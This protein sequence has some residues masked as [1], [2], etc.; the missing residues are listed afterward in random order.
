MAWVTFKCSGT[1][2]EATLA[3]NAVDNGW[4]RC[5]DGYNWIKPAASDNVCVGRITYLGAIRIYTEIG[6][7]GQL[8]TIFEPAVR[9]FYDLTGHTGLGLGWAGWGN[10]I[11]WAMRGESD[12]ARDFTFE[13][14]MDSNSI[15]GNVKPDPSITGATTFPIIFCVTKGYDGINRLVGLDMLPSG[16]AYRCNARLI[17]AA[18]SLNY[19]KGLQ[20][21]GFGVWGF[22]SKARLSKLYVFRGGVLAADVVNSAAIEASF[23]DLITGIPYV[24]CSKSQGVEV[25]NDECELVIGS[26]TYYYR[27]LYPNLTPPHTIML[28]NK[29]SNFNATVAPSSKGVDEIMTYWVRRA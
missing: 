22:D 7:T 3:Q 13:G 14:W 4:T 9:E 28:T 21:G 8:Y 26:N 5:Q 10:P 18:D 29:S 19:W 11:Y 16:A 12:L 25:Y 1:N 6:A 24:L 15:F 23:E 2:F 17:Y 27:C 20:S